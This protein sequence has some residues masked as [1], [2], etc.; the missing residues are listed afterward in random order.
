MCSMYWTLRAEVEL[1][2]GHTNDDWQ[3]HFMGKADSCLNYYNVGEQIPEL[4]HYS[5]SLPGDEWFIGNCRTCSQFY[6]LGA[7]IKGGC[8]V[9]VGVP[10]LDR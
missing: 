2:C 1:P 3:T 6:V 7:Q 4:G 8:V 10:V 9:R 5:G